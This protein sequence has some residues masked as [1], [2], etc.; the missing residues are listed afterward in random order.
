MSGTI[1][2]VLSG[3]CM[4]VSGLSYRLGAKGRAVPV[5]LMTMLGLGGCLLFAFLVREQ[6]KNFSPLAAAMGAAGGVTQYAAI[7]LL[8]EAMRRGPLAPPWCAISLGGFVPV[9]VFSFLFL[10]ERPGV[11]QIS[12]VLSACAAIVAASLGQSGGGS[13]S[14]G[15]RN[16]ALYGVLLFALLIVTGLL[17]IVLKYATILPG[18]RA[19]ENLMQSNGRV[20]MFFAYVGIALSSGTDLLLSRTWVSNRYAWL[21]GILLTAS[22]LVTYLMIV[23]ILDLPAVTVFTLCNTVSILSVALGA[24]IFLGEKPDRYWYAMLGFSILAILLNR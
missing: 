1:L 6:W 21:G 7:R 14:S 4:G 5:Q 10:R 12:A 20:L 22:G 18:C 13:R 19:G 16:M 17:N 9:I 3:V 2:A 15:I 24:A 11:W 8:R 23:S